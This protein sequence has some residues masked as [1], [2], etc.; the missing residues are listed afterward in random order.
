MVDMN[1]KDAGDRG[2]AQDD[3][4]SLFTGRSSIQVRANLTEMVPP[5]VVNMFHAYPEAN[6]NL[7][8]EPDYLDPIS[9]Y[10]GFK[11][12]LCQVARLSNA[13]GRS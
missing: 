9:G 13:E 12:L 2:I 10:P 4:V 11:S 5:G 8:V 7:L 6:V 1:P 3:W